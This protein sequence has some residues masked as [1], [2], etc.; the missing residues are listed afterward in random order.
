M[1]WGL[2]PVF[3]YE[4]LASSRRWQTYAVRAAGVA[5]ML[6]AVAMIALPDISY[7]RDQDW[8]AY[9]ELGE[10]FF[11]AIIGVALTLVMLAAPAA[12]AGAICVDRARG[13]LAHMLATDLS[14]PE[15][16]LGKLAARLLPVL[17]LIACSWPVLAITSLL[18]GID[19]IALNLA[20]AIIVAVALVG[21][22]MAMALSVWA[23]KP[24]EVVLVVYTFWMLA[25][26]FWPIWY[27][28][29]QVRVAGR[30]ED[31]ALVANPYY[32]AFAPYSA[33]GTLG[34]GD[35][36][37]FFAAALG[38]SAAMA[39][40][41]VWRMRPVARR[42]VGEGRGRA[43]RLGLLGRLVR[44]LPGPSLDG[45]PVLWREWHRS[46]PS[47]WVMALAVAVGGGSGVACVAA[48]VAIWRFG[49]RPGI[50]P[51]W[52]VVAMFGL[53]IHVAFGLLTLSASAPTS[54]A[55]ER[56][57]GSLD[58]LAA[59][60][61][62]TPAIV[63]GKWLGAMRPVALLAIGPAAMGLGLAM[64]ERHNW[65][66]SVRYE[67]LSPGG[68][69]VVAGLLVATPLVHG[70]L[71]AS[72]GVAAATWIAR[73]GR[74]IAVT[75]GFAVL[76]GA[77][78]PILGLVAR[79]ASPGGYGPIGLS[80]IVATWTL[81]HILV[82]PYFQARTFAGWVAFWDLECLALAL[83]LLWLTVRTFDGCFGRIPERPRRATVLA[84][85]VMVLAGM[86]GL[87]GLFG[88]IG[89]WTR[90]A[91]RFMAE[92]D[93]GAIMGILLVAVGLVLVAALSASSMSR[94]ATSPARPPS[95]VVGRR[96]FARRWWA[97]YRLV[98]LLATGPALMAVATATA[99]LP[100]RAGT[101][102]RTL[103]G[104]IVVQFETH[105]TGITYVWRRND[106]LRDFREATEAEMAAAGLATPGRIRARSLRL[107][108][109]AASVIPAHGAA[110]VGV[111]AMLG[112]AIRRRGAASAAS[113]G[114]ALFVTMLWPLG[115]LL[116]LGHPDYDWGLTL[117]S[118]IPAYCVLLF[119]MYRPEVIAEMTGW[120]GC[121]DLVM[122]LA[123]VI[124]TGLAV[125]ILDRRSRG[126]P[127]G[128]PVGPAV[129]D[130]IDP[131]MSRAECEPVAV[132]GS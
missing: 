17:G 30:P 11:Y 115:Y 45:N 72:V 132:R 2:G 130:G 44:R 8:R 89:V 40:L 65:S 21:C 9:A 20:F 105:P 64:A 32:L 35:Y 110:F 55:E 80:P 112:L 118:V 7:A 27:G 69:L 114:L 77:A 60:S 16:V 124:A 120:I 103:P 83:G 79:I 39:G 57:R 19:P 1:R 68:R 125:V 123:A 6:A 128:G 14:D 102:V 70:A 78:W 74:A 129:P 36:V 4:C 58:L 81:T 95:P 25:L 101:W 22:T 98:L 12:T 126:A 15:I 71:I 76:I 53:V 51:G 66:S 24:H 31:W 84:D 48:A 3:F 50:P 86:V 99:R 127:A 42:G 13:T 106:G 94:E 63:L 10:S 59:T 97:A 54:M 43:H 56:Q 52:V 26:L 34:L 49:L 117:A 82:A 131:G 67:D 73:Q 61:L 108:G 104:G 5:V 111:G 88:A 116:F 85:V 87:A 75:V 122:I 46:R 28:L 109:F 38:T 29:A 96:L 37:G 121:W 107:A 47:R 113:A 23:R 91:W 92:G 93:P 100:V 119:R 33:P 18:G 90:G 41:A 62:S